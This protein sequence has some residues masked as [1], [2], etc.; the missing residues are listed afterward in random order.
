MKPISKTIR[1]DE[2]L[3]RVIRERARREK[4]DESTAARQLLWRGAIDYSV[5][6]NGAGL[7]TYR[8]AARLCGLGVREFLEEIFVRGAPPDRPAA[9]LEEEMERVRELVRVNKRKKRPSY[10]EAVSGV[11]MAADRPRKNP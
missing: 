6:L 9:E 7:L 11:P 4:I 2:A 3:A 8:E 5:E 1:L 10:D